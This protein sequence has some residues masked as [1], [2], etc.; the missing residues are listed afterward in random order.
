MTP[1]MP[2]CPDIPETCGHGDLYPF[3]GELVLPEDSLDA[4]APHLWEEVVEG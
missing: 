4:H 3:V 1:K 2:S